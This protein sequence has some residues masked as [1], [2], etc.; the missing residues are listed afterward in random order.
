MIKRIFSV[1]LIFLFL[2]PV[3]ARKHDKDAVFKLISKSYTLNLDGSSEYRERKELKIFTT[4]TFDYFGETFIDYNPDFQNLIIN[5]AYVIREDGTKIEVP[6]NAFNNILPNNCTNCERLNN[7]REM[8]VT[9]TAL[10]HNATIILDYSIT[11]KNFFFKELFSTIEL[12]E[13][14][15]I[16]NFVLTVSVPDD[17]PLNW[18]L[19]FSNFKYTKSQNNN[20]GNKTTM[21]KFYN[22]PSKTNDSYLFRTSL[23]TISFY[24][25]NYPE[26]FLEKF[27]QQSAFTNFNDEKIDAF[28]KT[29]AADKSSD[30]EKIIAI[31]DYISDN[32]STKNVRL[33]LL[34]YILATPKH[35]W[36]TNCAL[37][38]EKEIFLTKILKNIGYDAQITFNVKDLFENNAAAVRL[39]LN[40]DT[41]YISAN[42]HSDLN[43]TAKLSPTTMILENG[44][45]EK[46]KNIGKNI[47]VEAEIRF[48]DNDIL[49]PYS[50]VLTKKIVSP[51]TKTLYNQDTVLAKAQVRQ[52]GN[53]YLLEINNGKY[54]TSISSDEIYRNRNHNINTSSSSELYIYSIILPNKYQFATTSSKEEFNIEGAKMIEN[55]EVSDHKLIII[56]QLELPKTGISAK[57]TEK[58]KEMM[59]RWET[60]KRIIIK[61]N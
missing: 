28:F 9:H 45:I 3:F 27:L 29:L 34:N 24:S 56:K 54:G 12:Y 42:E 7:I 40:K 59:G 21:W 8:V 36:E 37:P 60:P 44:N 30:L 6:E 11:S 43:L 53:S 58:F 46:L 51:I 25:F 57:N 22:L 23:P 10:E 50:N 39:L 52:I 15:P 1:F 4:M 49:K 38:L 13:V 61:K 32:I 2:L 33:E 26:E 20:N 5:E 14:V 41:L 47:H 19:N 17:K 31:K 16:E 55:I 18:N 48:T 35:V